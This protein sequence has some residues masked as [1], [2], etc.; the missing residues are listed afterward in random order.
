MNEKLDLKLAMWLLPVCVFYALFAFSAF[1][2]VT[3]AAPQSLPPVSF[4]NDIFPVLQQHCMRCHG[5]VMAEGDLRFDAGHDAVLTGGQT[6]NEILGSSSADSE[7]FRRITSTKPGYRMPKKGNA[8]SAAQVDLIERWLDQGASWSS[9]PETAVQKSESVTE[10][11]GQYLA[12]FTTRMEERSFRSLFWLCI[13]FA[14]VTLLSV[15]RTWRRRRRVL[16]G[17]EMAEDDA[18]WKNWVIGT[19]M[20]LLLATWIHY[21]GKAERAR[22][23]LAKAKDELYKFTGSPN[24]DTLEPP[25]PMHPKR[26]GG[27]YYRGNDE[28]NEALFN[29]GFYR[30]AQ[31][32]VWL[33]DES[34]KRLAWGDEVSGPL[35]VEFEIRRSANT[36]GELF[37]EQV[38]SRIA[39]ADSVVQQDGKKIAEMA[40]VTPGQVWKSRLPIGQSEDWEVEKHTQKHLGKLFV[41]Q[42]SVK[43]KPHYGIVFELNIVDGKIDNSSQLWMGALYDLKG[44]VLVPRGDKVLLDRWLDWRPIPEIEGRHTEDAEL[45]GLPEH[46]GNA[47][48]VQ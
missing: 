3:Q 13:G 34:G 21:D 32:E 11:A 28:R 20:V 9:E 10:Q 46:V 30:T 39:L 42:Q 8:L 48:D 37:T 4:E 16:A 24:E 33:V 43:P 40:C 47:S 27:V 25:Y 41:I 18:K 29:G 1:G 31:L 2:A 26:L 22:D 38:M 36:T 6:G 19:L 35:F 23:E 17:L 5:K 7:L 45:L 14:M 12:D 15:L 44:R